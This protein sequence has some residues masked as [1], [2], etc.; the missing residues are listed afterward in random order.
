[1]SMKLGEKAELTL[2]PDYAYGAMGSPPTI[3]A[4]ATLVFD[5]ELIQIA[6]RRPTR[7]MMSDPE[8]I[9]TAQHLKDQ[10]NIKFREKAL[11]IA[12]G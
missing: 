5:V 8:L 10:G 11:K 9:Q 7:W 2:K 6:D 4:D 1:M 12:E 3:P